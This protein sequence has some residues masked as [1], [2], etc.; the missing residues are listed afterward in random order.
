ML[1]VMEDMLVPNT[2]AKK[3]GLDL[4]G[5]SRDFNAF[6]RLGEHVGCN[7]LEKIHGL[8]LQVCSLH[9]VVEIIFYEILQ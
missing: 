2:S 9:F 5:L 7:L 6:N 8:D 3:Y 1:L 4:Q